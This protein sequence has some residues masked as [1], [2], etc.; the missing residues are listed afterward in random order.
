MRSLQLI[1]RKGDAAVQMTAE[2]DRLAGCA[3]IAAN[4]AANAINWQSVRSLM[5]SGGV[6]AGRKRRRPGLAAA[7][8][9]G[10]P[11]LTYLRD[12]VRQAAR[13]PELFG[14]SRPRPASRGRQRRFSRLQETGRLR[15]L[16]AGRG[17]ARQGR[18]RGARRG[19]EGARRQTAAAS[20]APFESRLFGAG[21]SP[22]GRRRRPAGSGL[23]AD[24]CRRVAGR[25]GPDG[26]P[27]QAACRGQPQGCRQP[28]LRRAAA[29]R[30]RQPLPR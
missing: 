12:R 24:P 2:L 25:Q 17:V 1:V 4:R 13:P 28:A 8:G 22:A 16:R 7:R 10:P 5:V 26:R 18:R 9:P 21:W 11:T 3:S 6:P 27:G 20:A 30:P 29:G 15:P 14:N 19:D 23:R